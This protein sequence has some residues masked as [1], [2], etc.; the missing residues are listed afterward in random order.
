MEVGIPEDGS[1]PDGQQLA[2]ILP[3]GRANL[4]GPVPGP[5]YGL[6]AFVSSFVGRSR[7]IEDVSGLLASARLVTLVGSGGMGKTRL[8]V[9]VAERLAPGWAFFVDLAP[10]HEPV[11]VREEIASAF[12]VGELRGRELAEVLADALPAGAL[13]VLDNCEHMIDASSEQADRLLRGCRGLRIL[14]TSQRRLEVPGEVV[15]SVPALALP[16]PMTEAAPEAVLESP[17]V[18][19]FCERAAAV[20]RDFVPSGENLAPTSPPVWRTASA[21]SGEEPVPA[22]PVTEPSRPP[23][24]GATSCFRSRSR[25]CCAGSRCSPAGSASTPP[26]KCVLE[27]RST[28]TRFSSFSQAWW[29]SHL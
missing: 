7:E 27:A 4:A 17:A 22:R 24:S 26:R 9:E 15:W 3:L 13:L 21:S 19:L 20:K 6:P 29:P 16:E 8:A 18:Q 1:L 23:C 25:S 5:G 28:A 14:A 12:A 10:V 11:L 2:K